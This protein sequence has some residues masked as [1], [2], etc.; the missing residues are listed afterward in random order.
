[1]VQC[2]APGIKPG[3]W[4]GGVSLL[5]RPHWLLPGSP[6][7]KALFPFVSVSN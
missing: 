7:K 3:P 6:W 5:L 1:M 4:E 2:S